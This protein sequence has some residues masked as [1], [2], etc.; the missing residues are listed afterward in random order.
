MI[1]SEWWRPQLQERLSQGDVLTAVPTTLASFPRTFLRFETG[2]GG[3]NQWV[4]NPIPVV[5][6][7]KVHHLGATEPKGCLVISH[8]CALDKGKFTLACAPVFAMSTL[9]EATQAHCKNQRALALLPLPEIPG[10]G[11]QYCDL[12]GITVATR[13]E[14]EKCTR[15]ASMTDAAIERLHAQIVAFFTNR[16]VP[17]QKK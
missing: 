14:I 10:L 16:Q 11:E 15:V 1:A 9:D 7:G 3:R 8:S 4:P 17:Q 5:R 12:R 13:T 6:A 2:K